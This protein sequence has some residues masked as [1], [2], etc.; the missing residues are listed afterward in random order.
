MKS[1]P[2]NY[3]RAISGD[4]PPF[5][6]GLTQAVDDW[7]ADL[8]VRALAE[9]LPAEAAAD[10]VQV[11]SDEDAWDVL[12]EIPNDSAAALVCPKFDLLDPRY[13]GSPSRRVGPKMAASA[14]ASIGSPSEVPVPC[15]SMQ[16]IVCGS[17]S[18]NANASSITLAWPSMLGAVNAPLSA[19]WTF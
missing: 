1:I 14:P 13:S 18:A 17:T 5:T 9:H 4:P 8:Y 3:N 10:G 11:F 15:V 6:K 19:V 7:A 2:F 12:E 16:V